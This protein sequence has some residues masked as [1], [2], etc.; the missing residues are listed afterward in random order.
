MV[1]RARLIH[2][3]SCFLRFACVQTNIRSRTAYEVQQSHDWRYE[4]VIASFK[5]FSCLKYSTNTDE[6]ED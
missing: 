2:S 6:S 4:S 1:M 3:L 5:T